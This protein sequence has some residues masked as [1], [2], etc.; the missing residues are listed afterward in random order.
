MCN[1]EYLDV[2]QTVQR[3]ITDSSNTSDI[4]HQ[5]Q[6][7][8]AQKEYVSALISVKLLLIFRLKMT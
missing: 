1:E 8:A 2:R 4:F 3:E 5:G 7:K 6:M